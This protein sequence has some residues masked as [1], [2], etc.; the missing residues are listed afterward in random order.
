MT[1]DM[2]KYLQWRCRVN[3]H[4]KYHKYI[5]EWISNVIDTQLSY[6]IREREHLINSGEYNL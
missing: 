1:H 5:D 6:F 4:N 2:K 3:W